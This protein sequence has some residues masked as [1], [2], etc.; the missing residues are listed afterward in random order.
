MHEIEDQ[1]KGNSDPAMLRASIAQVREKSGNLIL[2]T[3]EDRPSL[4]NN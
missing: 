4:G 3:K 2:V 1:A